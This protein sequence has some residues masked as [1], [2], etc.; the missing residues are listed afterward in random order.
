MWLISNSFQ[1][2]NLKQFSQLIDD[3]ASAQGENQVIRHLAEYFSSDDPQEDKD[4]TLKLL[5]GYLPARIMSVRKLKNLA[6]G[7]TGFPSWLIDRCEQETGNFLKTLALISVTGQT[8]NSHNSISSLVTDINALK[9][10]PDDRITTFISEQMKDSCSSE[11]M[12]VLKLLTGT[13]NIPVRKYEI[14]QAL[15]K[16]TGIAFEIISVRLYE[17]EKKDFPGL[18]NLRLPVVNESSLTPIVFS[19]INRLHQPLESLGKADGWKAFGTKKGLRAQ[20]VKYGDT[21]H[22]WTE[23]SNIISDMFPEIISA[24]EKIKAPLVLDGQLVSQYP[25]HILSRI[26]KKHISKKEIEQNPVRYETW[27]AN[28]SHMLDVVSALSDKESVIYLRTNLSFLDWNQLNSIHKSCHGLGYS[29]LMLEQVNDE[30]YQYFWEAASHSVNAQLM[31]VETGNMHS[32]GVVSMT[33]GLLENKGFVPIV[34]INA[35]DCDIE[36]NEI[37][38]YTRM[39]TIDR[40][41]PVRNVAPGLIYE[42]QFEDISR[43]ARRKSGF[44]LSGA[45][46]IKRTS[47]EVKQPDKLVFLKKLLI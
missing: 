40:F 44:I 5:L 16:V 41:G 45:K 46:L 27:R 33:F 24:A 7:L 35:E 14:L 1:N 29:G 43:A 11:L 23:D 32:W 15:A 21:A 12:V 34:K 28:D 31:Y 6:T 3:I 18:E 17:Q 20:L 8:K 39:H 47:G 9:G 10:L 36:L 37:A 30:R 42:L 13:F 38:E 26:H 25:D 4:Q 2:Q 19:S 22:L